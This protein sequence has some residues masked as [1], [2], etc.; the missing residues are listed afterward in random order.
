MIE[1]AFLNP[2]FELKIN[3]AAFLQQDLVVYPDRD[4][5]SPDNIDNVIRFL[6]GKDVRLKEDLVNGYPSLIL[7]EACY[8]LRNVR[9]INADWTFQKV[10]Q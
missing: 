5:R 7:E 9:T 6:F 3:R 10:E 2:C 8:E 1:K 4:E